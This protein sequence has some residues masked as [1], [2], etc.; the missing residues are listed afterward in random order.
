MHPLLLFLALAHATP[1]PSVS[2]IE[3]PVPTLLQAADV[4]LYRVIRVQEECSG[5][6]GAHLTLALV[7]AAWGD[8]PATVDAGGHAFRHAAPDGAPGLGLLYVLPVQRRTPPP[9]PLGW[10]IAPSGA[11][12]V[13]LGEPSIGRSSEGW[14]QAPTQR[15]G[16][17]RIAELKVLRAAPPDH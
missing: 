11:E 5:M 15:A 2:L 10:C 4:G 17:D 12:G 9:P 14:L 3:D 8:P 7:E 6:G 16:Q 13:V 1:P